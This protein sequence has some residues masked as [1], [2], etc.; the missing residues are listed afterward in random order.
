MNPDRNFHTVLAE[1]D[2]RALNTTDKGLKFERL[3]KAFIQQDKAQQARFSNVWL[4]NEWPGHG[5]ENDS[6]IDVVAEERDTGRIIGIQCKFY[7]PS[8]RVSQSDVSKFITR[9]GQK[10]IDAGIFVATTYDWTSTAEQALQNQ[11]KEIRSWRPDVFENSSIDWSTFSLE[12]PSNLT[13]RQSK[14]LRDYQHDALN[15]VVAGFEIHERGKMIMPCGSGK[16]FVA[17]RIAEHMV[18]ADGSVLFLTP[19]ISLLDQSLKDWASDAEIPLKTFAVCSDSTAGQ[20]TEEDASPYDLAEAPSTNSE[21]L[22]A[23]YKRTNRQGRM[24]VIFSTYQSLDVVAAAQKTGKVPAFDLIVC[25]EAHR[26]TGVSNP[27]NA[28]ENESNFK[29]VH[30]NEFINA[31]RRLYMTATPRIYSENAQQ[32]A[33]NGEREVFSMDDENIYGP[34]FHYLGFG[35]AVELDILSDYKVVVLNVNTGVA[36]DVLN[37]LLQGNN[38][39]DTNDGAKLIGCWNGLGKQAASELDFHDDPQPTKRAV[40]FCNT[41]DNSKKLE[42]YF[43]EVVAACLSKPEQMGN[44]RLQVDVRHADGTQGSR[45]RAKLLAWLRQEPEDGICKVLTNARCLVEGVDVPALDAVIFAHPKRSEIDVVQA[46]GRVMRKSEGK[47]RGYI[48]LPVVT[49]PSMNP[50]KALNSGTYAAVW[51][52]INAICAHDDRF[53]S[54]INQLK[55]TRE[56]REDINIGGENRGRSESG[57]NETIS[58][59][60]GESTAIQGTL[61]LD[62][63]SAEIRDAILAR[64]VDRHSDPKYWDKWIDKTKQAADNHETRI[65]SMLKAD[66]DQVRTTFDEFVAGLRQTLNDDVDEQMAVGLLSQHMVSKPIFDALFQD[67]DFSKRNPVSVAMEDTLRKLEGRGLEKETRNLDPFYREIRIRIDALDT[68]QA[69]QQ[70]IAEFYQRFFKGALGSQDSGAALKDAAER[71]GIV[72][73]PPEAVDYVLQSVE[74]ILQ[75]DFGASL[76][77]EGVH[78]MDPFV[79]TGTFITRLIRNGLIRPEDLERKY[80]KELHAHEMVLLAYYIAAINIEAAYHQESGAAEYEPFPGIVFTDTLQ[81]EESAGGRQGVLFGGNDDRA[82]RN[83]RLDIRVFT[84]NPPWSAT[85]NREYPSIRGR[86]RNTYAALSNTRNIVALYDPYVYAIRLASDRVMLSPEGGIVAFILNGGFVDSNAFDGFRKTVAK[87]FHKVYCYNLRGDA[88]TSGERRRSEGGNIFDAGTRT[89]VAILI[90]VKKPERVA[91]P[92][93]LYYR[94]IGDYLNREDKIDILANSRLSSTEWEIIQPNE[95]G[96]WIRQRGESFQELVPLAPESGETATDHIFLMK[97]IGIQTG[98]DAWLYNF[99][100]EKLSQQINDSIAFYNK[101]ADRTR[102]HPQFQAARTARQKQQAAKELVNHDE[103][104][105][106]W[107]AKIYQHLASGKTYAAENGRFETGIYRPFNKA[108]TYV[109]EDLTHRVGR[110]PEIFPQ[111]HQGNIGISAVTSGSGNEF[112]VIAADTMIDSELTSHS[113]YFPRYRYIPANVLTRLPD[114]NNPELEKVSNINPRALSNFQAHYDDTSIADDDLFHY[115]Y[116]VLHSE[117]YR[118]EFAD[119][120]SK[121]PARIPMAATLDE[122][123]SFVNAGE[124]LMQLHVGY[125]ATEPYPLTETYAD[126]WDAANPDAYRVDKM[127]YVRGRKDA[128]EYNASITLSDIPEDAHEYRLGSRS[129]LDWLIERYQVRTHQASG[130][131]NDPNDWCNEH[132]DPRYIIDLVKRVTTVS[133]Q[134]VNIVR[135]LPDLNLSDRR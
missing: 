10:D 4:W 12:K 13:R 82:K 27:Q 95:H 109:S 76:S 112:H 94:D 24:T 129:A 87:E 1:L 5:N 73:T 22:A 98:R 77:D 61:I 62:N 114:P 56:K 70:V 44:N 83:K 26:T 126:G 132:G 66:D 41:I 80:R 133:V 122:F 58:N 128:I 103:T 72:Y 81:S 15:D 18:G 7:G 28:E 78:V 105:F 9:V 36:S 21:L 130:I 119:D 64:I 50:E 75:Q 101:N 111:N 43:S 113:V 47:K 100:Q 121:E 40:A 23:R 14:E 54:R 125:E 49:T 108:R 96:D 85:D 6:G 79:G 69:R 89:T 97:S 71:M 102:A 116:G 32:T 17:L 52:V 35:R 29:R 60:D 99:S 135:N 115:V 55:L 33:R 8:S 127:R 37:V 63:V 19:S 31:K 117:Q 25:D 38:S 2:Q 46:V 120:L 20:R 67:Y 92:A 65:R 88:R 68:P 30:D 48:I 106:H 93:T 90:L 107:N 84:G 123:R 86:V 57:D 42:S 131:V 110:F 51:Q 34:E 53:E 91:K 11:S 3:V 124:R 104:Q 118:E 74:D 59:R 134:T 45:Q 39:L 16:T